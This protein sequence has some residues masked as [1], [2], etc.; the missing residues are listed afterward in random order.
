L[1]NWTIDPPAILFYENSSFW[2]YTMSVLVGGNKCKIHPEA[3]S[4]GHA[5]V[6]SRGKYI[7]TF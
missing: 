7:Y 2:G 4:S 1:C 5:F 3:I 6:I